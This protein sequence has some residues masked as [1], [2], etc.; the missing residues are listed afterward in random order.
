MKRT[1]KLPGIRVA[2]YRRLPNS[3]GRDFKVVLSEITVEAAC[4][5]IAVDEAI[6]TFEKERGLCNWTVLADGYQ[7]VERP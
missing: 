6:R 2:F 5:D 4:P 1:Q 7:V 3:Y